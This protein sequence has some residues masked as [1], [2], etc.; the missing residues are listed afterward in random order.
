MA[1]RGYMFIVMFKMKMGEAMYA[2][3]NISLIDF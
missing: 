2:E 3:C 1:D